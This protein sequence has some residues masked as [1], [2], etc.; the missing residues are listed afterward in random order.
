[1]S[2]ALPLTPGTGSGLLHLGGGVVAFTVFRLLSASG[3]GC[4]LNTTSGV[5]GWAPVP[6]MAKPQSGSLN[7][8]TLLLGQP[9]GPVAQL[10]SSNHLRAE[11][12]ILCRDTAIFSLES[13]LRLRMCVRALRP[14]EWNLGA[15]ASASHPSGP[16]LR[17]ITMLRP[18]L[19]ERE[20]DTCLGLTHRG[21]Q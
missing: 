18:G 14:L 6:E 10:W 4:V 11:C 19:C 1:M 15:P 9:R 5:C 17:T 21:P 2:P 16:H 3:S 7:T 12:H 8:K 20:D 13:N